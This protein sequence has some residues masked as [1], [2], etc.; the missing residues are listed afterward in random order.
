MPEQKD[1]GIQAKTLISELFADPV[2]LKTFRRRR[3]SLL[4]RNQKGKRESLS[5][6]HLQWI[7]RQA[8][9]LVEQNYVHLPMK[10]ALHAIDPV[11][12]LKLLLARLEA[13]GGDEEKPTEAE[14]HRE[15]LEAFFSLRDPHT[16][17]EL[18]DYYDG[19]VAFLPFMVED[20]YEKGRRKYI[21]SKVIGGL[22]HESFVPGVE[23]RYWNGMSMDRAVR[24]HTQQCMGSNPDARHAEALLSLTLRVL[25]QTPEPDH[26]WAHVVYRTAGGRELEQK[27]EWTVVTAGT[28][29]PPKTGGSRKAD[30]EIHPKLATMKD[31]QR[32]LFARNVMERMP[33]RR[34]LESRHPDQFRADEKE[35]KHGT[36]GYLRIWSFELEEEAFRD[37]F[38][39][40]IRSMPQKGLIIDVRENPGG[41][42]SAAEY[43]LKAL[44]PAPIQPQPLQ[45]INTLLNLQIV[46]ARRPGKDMPD[47]APWRRAIAEG[48][49]TGGVYSAAYPKSDVRKCNELKQQYFGPVVVITDA[50]T[51]SAAEMFAAGVQDHRIG[52]VLGTDRR[53]GGGGANTW[54]YAK[55]RRYKQAAHRTLPAGVGFRIAIRRSLR[56]GLHEGALLEDFGVVRDAPHR[57]TRDDVLRDNRELI[58]SAG[59]LLAKMFS[60]TAGANGVTVKLL[61]RGM[62]RIEAHLNGRRVRVI[63]SPDEEETLILPGG[64]GGSLL[65]IHGFERT[66]PI[67]CY[68]ARLD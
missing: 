13:E 39:R 47:L 30:V 53:T 20:I 3:G 12:R 21:V 50:L 60:V 1:V 25:K 10:R 37:E 18:P 49:Q 2:D 66:T 6:R 29:V 56:V 46:N 26:D 67:A 64:R 14:L 48:L 32:I 42:M 15:L 45:F 55:F 62:T 28:A 35:T 40:L 59:A 52:L 58:E 65:E 8:L 7:V 63:E 4:W 41:R 68:R 22:D 31:M 24:N 44:T 36:F 17:Y 43:V 16:C 5:L 57:V 38:V 54:D 33:R 19:K 51:Y 23:I 34:A 9:V 61:S 11:Q 27:F